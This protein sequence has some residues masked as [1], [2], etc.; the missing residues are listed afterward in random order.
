MRTIS[1][2]VNRITLEE[3]GARCA[4]CLEAVVC[5]DCHPPEPRTYD[6]PGHPGGIEITDVRVEIY[7]DDYAEIRRADRPDWFEVLDNI[8]ARL[9]TD[10]LLRDR[11][12]D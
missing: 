8:A 9:V 10:D 3:L 6:Y 1:S 7:S 5:F 4:I 2:G 11:F 12:L